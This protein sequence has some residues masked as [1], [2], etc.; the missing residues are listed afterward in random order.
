MQARDTGRQ[1]MGLMSS[2]Q[3]TYSEDLL[4]FMQGVLG[5][6]H[7]GNLKLSFFLFLMVTLS[8]LYLALCPMHKWHTAVE[9]HYGSAG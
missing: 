3:N 1:K 4:I 6:K 5:E 7:E 2:E 8:D 9:Q